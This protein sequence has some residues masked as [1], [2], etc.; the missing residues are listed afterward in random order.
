[1]E[2]FGGELCNGFSPT[3]VRRTKPVKASSDILS[4]LPGNVVTG[5]AEVLV[6]AAVL[7]NVV[8]DFCWKCGRLCNEPEEKSVL[9][10]LSKGLAFMTSK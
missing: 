6:F 10:S 9:A 8:F 3:N 5:T 4:C 2:Q 1:M 7:K